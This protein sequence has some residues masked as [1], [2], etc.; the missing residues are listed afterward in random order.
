MATHIRATALSD[1]ERIA[2]IY[3]QGI[4]E[5]G[6]TFE[7][8]LR[9]AEDREEWI[10]THTGYPAV[11][12][13][14]GGRVVGFAYAGE[15]RPREC[16]RGIGEFSVYMDREFRGHGIGKVLLNALIEEARK[17]GYWKL[18]SRIFDFNTAS[19]QLCK[20]CG[21]REVG[22][23]EKHGKLDGRWIDCVIRRSGSSAKRSTPDDE[24]VE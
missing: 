6:S 13:E 1:A 15:Y 7:T 20:A 8:E 21:F 18:V 14:H 16:Y 24:P 23:Y 4:E 22:V 9:T 19:R 12:A 2:E 5:R 10:R 17:L 3:N 11:V